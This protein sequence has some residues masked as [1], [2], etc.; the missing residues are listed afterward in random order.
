MKVEERLEDLGLELIE[1]P[2]EKGKLAAAV[3]SGNL[4]FTSGHTSER[5]GKLGR[6]VTAAEG[7]LVAQDAAIRCLSSIKALIGDLDKVT[8]VVKILGFVN[9][10][11]GFTEQ[12]QVMHGATELLTDIFGDDVGWHARSAIGVYQLPD[13]AAVEIEMIVEVQD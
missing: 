11:D 13:N 6:E 7:Y 10:A 4:V 5:R 12:P 9:S 3:R 2:K 8:R 1:P